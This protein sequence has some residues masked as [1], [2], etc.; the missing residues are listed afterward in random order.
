MDKPQNRMNEPWN[1]FSKTGAVGA[2]L[3]YKA[4]QKQYERNPTGE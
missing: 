3:L 4:M 1:E 2:Y